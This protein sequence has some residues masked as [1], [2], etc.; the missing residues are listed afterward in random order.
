MQHMGGGG[1]GQHNHSNQCNIIEWRVRRSEISLA[2]CAAPWLRLCYSLSEVLFIFHDMNISD[3][4]NYTY[5]VYSLNFIRQY[6]PNQ[7]NKEELSLIL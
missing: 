3:T 1:G 5:I 7:C 6:K 2:A 4:V